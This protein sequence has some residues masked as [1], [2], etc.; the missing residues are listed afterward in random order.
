[1]TGDLRFKDLGWLGSGFTDL[2][3][4][5]A[6]VCPVRSGNDYII[7]S[8]D[9]KRLTFGNI[10]NLHPQTALEVGKEQE[11]A[12]RLYGQ[13][14]EDMKPYQ[15]APQM[16]GIHAAYGLLSEMETVKAEVLVQSEDG[17]AGVLAYN[18]LPLMMTRYNM[19]YVS[20]VSVEAVYLQKFISFAKV[21][22]LATHHVEKEKTERALLDKH[23][24]ESI[25]PNSLEPIGFMD[26]L[27][28]C[29]PVAMTLPLHRQGCAWHFYRNGMP[30]FSKIVSEGL[31]RESMYSI[32]PLVASSNITGW[33]KLGG[34]GEKNIWRY[35]SMCVNG[36][37]TLFR[38]LNDVRNFAG[39]DGAIDFYKM[40]QAYSAVRL[41][42]ADLAQMH[43][44]SDG[45]NRVTYALGMLDKLANLRVQLGGQYSRTPQGESA[46]MRE[47]CAMSQGE[48]LKRVFRQ[49]LRIVDDGMTETF[50][51]MVDNAY[52]ELHEHLGNQRDD[53]AQSE[54]VRLE[55]L[56]SQR[57]LRHG[58]FLSG[59][60]FE[61]L[62]FE[63]DG[64]V[65]HTIATIPFL[66]LVAFML[67]PKAFLAFK[68]TLVVER[69]ADVGEPVTA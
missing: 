34:M 26:A 7:P 45:H 27:T 48:E 53:A 16:I 4:R 42:F 18:A 66:L 29:S 1:M 38:H 15:P 3:Q 9:S 22:A 50:C 63:S 12:L 20:G 24:M 33:Q 14:P 31:T 39:D 67:D 23:A 68:P 52:Q 60:Q 2:V 25:V 11:I 36:I 13:V 10:L 69:M 51:R 59:K 64:S 55:R 21:A 44:S 6:G 65:P 30:V 17:V 8:K 49:K 19:E 61:S 43:C 41:V 54:T 47:L 62:F 37:N 57:N 28:R 5:W 46:A 35:L 56:R 40:V 58:A 32:D